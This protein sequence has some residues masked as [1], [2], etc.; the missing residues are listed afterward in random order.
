MNDWV[1]STKGRLAAFVL[2][3][4]M[5]MVAVLQAEHHILVERLTKLQKQVQIVTK[6]IRL[7]STNHVITKTLTLP[8]KPGTPG[9]IVTIIVTKTVPNFTKPIPGP[10]GP[11]GPRGFPG[12]PGRDGKN[13]L[14][15]LQGVPGV[16]P[17]VSQV[18]FALCAKATGVL[19]ALCKSAG[20]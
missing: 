2:L 20:F 13:G 16:S 8:G 6:E 12:K 10:I 15:G 18:L 7:P 5:A 14:Q 19:Q 3:F 17:T 1:H 11:Q 9:K 4:V